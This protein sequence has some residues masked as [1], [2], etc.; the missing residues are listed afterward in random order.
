MASVVADELGV[1]HPYLKRLLEQAETAQNGSRNPSVHPADVAATCNRGVSVSLG[2]SGRQT[3][4]GDAA[5]YD[6]SA[7][8]ETV[9]DS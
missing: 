6:F 7:A 9:G 4:G 3:Y 5:T 1:G 2:R 8:L